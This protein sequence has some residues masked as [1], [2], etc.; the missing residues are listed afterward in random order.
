MNNYSILELIGIYFSIAFV[1]CGFASLLIV[2]PVQENIFGERDEEL[3]EN[4]FSLVVLASV[5]FPI[6]IVL[7]LVLIFKLFIQYLFKGI[8]L[9]ISILTNK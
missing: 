3:I 2:F 4:L 8:Q 9:T 1:F 7:L 5:L 6:S